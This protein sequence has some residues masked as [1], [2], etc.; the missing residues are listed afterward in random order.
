[1]DAWILDDS[2]GTY[3]WGVIELPPLAADEV[4]VR[5]VTSALNHLDLWIT[6]GLPR[7]KL[8]HVPGC[9]AAG[10]IESIGSAVTHLAV[11]DEVVVNPGISP[12]ED[13]VAFGNN[14][15]VPASPLSANTSG[16]VT[17][18][19]FKLRPETSCAVPPT[20]RGP[21][22]LHIRSHTSPRT[23]CCSGRA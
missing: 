7:P 23:G 17:Q 9:D 3:R 2:P 16:A 13:I 12:V 14:S 8:P 22:V 15:P 18:P 11:G 4:R 6:R 5:V 20:G 21:N 19:S 10:V 1:M